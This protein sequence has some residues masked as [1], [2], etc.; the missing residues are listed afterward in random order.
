MNSSSG[1]K[2]SVLGFE[3]TASGD[4]STIGGG[5]ANVTT[6]TISVIAG[7]HANTASSEGGTIG[8]GAHNS[9]SGPYAT[10]PGGLEN[11]ASGSYAIAAGG[12]HNEANGD[13]SFAAGRRAQALTHG[14]FVWADHED[15]DFASTGEDQFIIR[16]RGGVGIGTN[17]PIGALDVAGPSGDSSVNLPMSSISAPEILD[18]PGIAAT[19]SPDIINLTQQASVPQMLTQV[20]IEAPAAGYVVVHGS[21]TLEVYG[22]ARRNQAYIQIAETASQTLS[23]WARLAGPG[24]NDSPNDAHYFDLNVDQIYFVSAGS[25]TFLLEGL[26]HPLNGSGAVTAANRPQ[27]I[28]NFYT[29]S[30]GAVGGFVGSQLSSQF[31]NPTPVI[32]PNVADSLSTLATDQY[33]KVDLRELELAT[34]RAQSQ[35]AALEKQ[36]LEAKLRQQGTNLQK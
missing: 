17:A 6:G 13:W 18:E 26:A 2:T 34:M 9:V 28:A 4:S 19:I 3:N 20:T 14:S 12:N 29:T 21:I 11:S 27:I 15:A 36:L 7:G 35:A 5:S 31:T 25:H 16:A 10:I 22:T 23:P 1:S 30:Y 8:G 32:W 33:Y 24:E